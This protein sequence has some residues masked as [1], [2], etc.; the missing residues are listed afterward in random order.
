MGARAFPQEKIFLNVSLLF[1]EMQ[2][3]T[4]DLTPLCFDY[5]GPTGRS[6]DSPPP[7]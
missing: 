5:A 6:E 2:L 3:L 7:Q 4:P 1:L